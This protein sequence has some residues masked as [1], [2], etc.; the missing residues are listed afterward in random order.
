MLEKFKQDTIKVEFEN[1]FLLYWDCLNHKIIEDENYFAILKSKNNIRSMACFIVNR[2]VVCNFVCSKE[3]TLKKGDIAYLF[4]IKNKFIYTFEC[5]K[6]QF[7]SFEKNCKY[8]TS[9]LD[10][11]EKNRNLV[12]QKVM[13]YL[14][15]TGIPK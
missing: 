5:L 3:T 2:E 15:S 10:Y 11:I 12:F 13:V 6:M 4:L 1:K 9:L 8:P 7:D 14:D